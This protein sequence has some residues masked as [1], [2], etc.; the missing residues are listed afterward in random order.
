M[1]KYKQKKVG[2]MLADNKKQTDAINE[3][4]TPSQDDVISFNP[5]GDDISLRGNYKVKK[6]VYDDKAF[7]FDRN[8]GFFDNDQLQFDIKYDDTQ[9]E[10]VFEVDF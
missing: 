1:S 6:L 7:I 8:I 2:A 9:E 3:N 5:M 10:V 4:I